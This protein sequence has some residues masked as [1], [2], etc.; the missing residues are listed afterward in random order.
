MVWYYEC[1]VIA[2]F[3]GRN[4]KTWLRYALIKVDNIQEEIYVLDISRKFEPFFSLNP[5]LT[6]E[7]K[8]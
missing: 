6:V 8:F 2:Y 4:D 7:L 5:Q 3:N 1:V